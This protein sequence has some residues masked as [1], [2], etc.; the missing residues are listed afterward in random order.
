VRASEHHDAGQIVAPLGGQARCRR[1]III[2]IANINIA[3]TT[4]VTTTATATMH[5]SEY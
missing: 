1:I 2:I 3:V 4:C 5:V